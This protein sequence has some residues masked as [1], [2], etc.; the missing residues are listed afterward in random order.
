MQETTTFNDLPKV[1]GQVL[2]KVERLER[3]LDI[4]KDEITRNHTISSEHIPMTLDE[5]CDFLKMKKSTMYY[6]VERGNITATKRGKNYIFFKDELIRWL[7]SG[8]KNQVS[9]TYEEE[10]T[11]RKASFKRKPRT[12]LFK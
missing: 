9:L 3:V 2:N 1:V 4:I 11:A 7:E 6:H 8:R 10:N 12:N 5:A